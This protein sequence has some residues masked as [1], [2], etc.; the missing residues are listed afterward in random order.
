MKKSLHT[1][2]IFLMFTFISTAQRM[3]L[4]SH[5]IYKEKVKI[6]KD[7][8]CDTR[9]YIMVFEDNF[10]KLDTSNWLTYYPYPEPHKRI[11]SYENCEHQYFKDENVIVKNGICHLIAKRDTIEYFGR[12][13]PITSGMIHSKIAIQFN[14]GRFEMRCKLPKGQGF[15]SAFWLWGINGEID[16]FETTGNNP[17]LQHTN[18][19]I[20]REQNGKTIFKNFSKAIK[21]IDS[22]DGFHTYI[23]EW[24]EQEVVWLTDGVVIRR[25]PRYWNF[26]GNP[27][28]CP[29]KKRKRYW[30]NLM[31]PVTWEPFN[32]IAGLGIS[33][34]C[35]SWSPPPSA[36]VVFP[37]SMEIDYI[38]VYQRKGL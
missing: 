5:R 3:P 1:F 34:E 35:N 22:S 28:D 2:L 26:L 21:T 11:H 29:I 17:F 18:V 10:N 16:I 23:V 12:T 24:S 13:Y 31:V 32:I 27:V 30:Q 20:P 15:W 19:H 8:L 7:I 6:E 37:Q 36:N 25:L 14:Y 4:F 9:P 38:R 33:D